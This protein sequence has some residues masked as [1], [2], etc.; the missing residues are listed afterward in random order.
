MSENNSAECGTVTIFTNGIA[1]FERVYTLPKGKAQ[2]L[3]LTFKD[4]YLGDVAGSIGVFGREPSEISILE[5]PS[6]APNKD[7][8]NLTIC[9]KNVTRELAGKLSGARVNVV[10]SGGQQ[11]RK[12]ILM[13]L[14]TE[15]QDHGTYK[16]D[17]SFIC[18]MEENG[19]FIHRISLDHVA[20]LSFSD[21]SIQEEIRKALAYNLE[22]TK[23]NS[24]PVYITL[25]GNKEESTAFINYTIPS[26]AWKS[27]YRARQTSTGIELDGFA[28]IDNDTDED[29]KNFV[30]EVV[31]GCPITFATDL[32]KIRIPKRST[33]NLISDSTQKAV[34]T[35]TGTAYAANV[36]PASAPAGSNKYGGTDIATFKRISIP[37]ER[38]TAMTSITEEPRETGDFSYFK[39][40]IPVTIE[41]HKSA[42]LPIFNMKLKDATVVLHYNYNNNPTRT[43]RCVRMRN[44]AKYTLGY[45][46]CT[47]SD[48]EGN[49]MGSC[50][51]SAVKPGESTMLSHA[52]ETGVT[53][54]REQKPIEQRTTRLKISDGIIYS[55]VTN[56]C[57]TTYTF[58]NLKEERFKILVDHDMA[59]RGG[60][61]QKSSIPVKEKL[62]NGVRCEMTLEPNQ[63]TDPIVITEYRVDKNQI[64]MGDSIGQ[65]S[66][67][68]SMNWIQQNVIYTKNPLCRNEAIM[69]C[70]KIQKEMDAVDR[71]MSSCEKL[72]ASCERESER[73]RKN[74]AAGGHGPDMDTWKTRL[75]EAEK[76]IFDNEKKK[77]P[78]MT[79]RKEILRLK[80]QDALTK[81]SASWSN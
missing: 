71:E 4:E 39:V 8:P 32:A 76:T 17:K 80:L 47:V 68:D 46:Q 27:S 44:E 30:I 20:Y 70:V 11:A 38:K 75:A 81:I 58:K 15:P 41:A 5:Y 62:K 42:V 7:K 67:L 25:K 59:L 40:A 51:F 61:V 10:M 9:P 43:M 34:E 56:R 50:V 74:L 2:R 72:T 77:L 21:E 3:S 23:P 54:I 63:T 37:L 55:E 16:T 69:E 14:E 52:V 28:I 73:L 26:P 19:C 13:G 1:S 66:A 49:Y 35:E 18:V 24:T 31:T 12:G 6:Y 53:V 60:E 36:A 33:V 79:E 48:A 29:W 45:G 78:N 65:F 64:S 57:D 22:Q